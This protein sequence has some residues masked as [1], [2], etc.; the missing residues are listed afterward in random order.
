[1]RLSRRT[2]TLAARAVVLGF[3]TPARAA[4]EY[5]GLRQRWADFILGEPVTT[6]ASEPFATQLSDQARIASDNWRSPPSTP[7]TVP[8]P[9]G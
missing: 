7:P 9:I 5:D 4:D 8:T 6:P 2:F 3:V 1:M